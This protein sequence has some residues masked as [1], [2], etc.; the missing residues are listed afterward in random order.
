MLPHPSP[1]REQVRKYK[2]SP[3]LPQ[4]EDI[5]ICLKYSLQ[6]FGFFLCKLRKWTQKLQKKIVSNKTKTIGAK[7]T[8]KPNALNIAY[9]I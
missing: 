5:Y 7:N 6:K 8:L 1:L 2:S 9:W 3:E 4:F